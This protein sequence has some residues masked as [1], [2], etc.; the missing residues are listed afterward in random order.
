MTKQQLLKLM[1]K[2]KPSTPEEVEHVLGTEL[3]FAGAGCF[4]EVYF[5]D[6]CPDVVIKFPLESDRS[7]GI[8]HAR[9][10]ARK[11]KR[12][13]RYAVLRNH[14]PEIL[15]FDRKQGVTVVPFIQEAE[16]QDRHIATCGLIS[17][18]IKHITGTTVKDIDGDNAGLDSRNR[19]VIVDVGY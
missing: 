1:N 8:T 4:R 7:Y 10:E 5:L 17:K 15:Y 11:I 3:H 12:L 19:L 6:N 18:L 2:Y 14:V 16:E 9:H 13:R